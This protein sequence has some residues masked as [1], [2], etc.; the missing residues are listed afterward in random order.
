MTISTQHTDKWPKPDRTSNSG[1][2]LVEVMTAA[3]LS[4]MI[5]GAILSAFVFIGRSGFRARSYS[6]IESQIRRGLDTFSNDAR[7]ARDIVW[8]NSQSITLSLPNAGNGSQTVT[9]AYDSSATGATA[10]S[11]YRMAGVPGSG[12]P[13]RIL[14]TKVDPSFS[15]SRFK[16]E[17]NG[18]T[19]NSASN[20]LETKLIQIN[21]KVSRTGQTT[22]DSTQTSRSARYLLRNKRVSN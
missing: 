13:R 20:D 16:L 11:F 10:R 17:Q 5:L 14:V 21:L 8:N 12:N 22:G 3:A 2:T 18:V 4:T 9:Y 15:F 1:F 7:M 19:D 6:E